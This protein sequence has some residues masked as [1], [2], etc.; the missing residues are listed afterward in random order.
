ME[1]LE[2]QIQ[3][4]VNNVRTTDQL[5][6]IDYARKKIELSLDLNQFDLIDKR[7][8]LSRLTY[9]RKYK[10][11]QENFREKYSD[12]RVDNKSC[13]GSDEHL[14]KTGNSQNQ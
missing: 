2:I 1:Q 14:V 13:L 12:Y 11:Y 3:D 7:V 4:D 5:K 9:R 6:L 10:S 8:I